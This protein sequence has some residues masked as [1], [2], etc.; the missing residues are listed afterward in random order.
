MRKKGQVFFFIKPYFEN[1]S[2][3]IL[4]WFFLLV[5]ILVENVYTFRNKV[6]HFFI[7]SSSERVSLRLLVPAPYLAP[8]PFFPQAQ[9]SL[10]VPPLQ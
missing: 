1:T 9:A 10:P 4:N 5:T 8:P 7:L 2:L 6:Q 3:K